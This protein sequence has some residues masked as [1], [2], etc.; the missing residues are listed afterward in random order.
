MAWKSACD[1][2]ASFALVIAPFALPMFLAP[3][4]AASVFSITK[5][6][7]KL[8]TIT[9]DSPAIALALLVLTATLSLACKEPV[10]GNS[11]IIANDVMVKGFHRS[12]FMSK[13]NVESMADC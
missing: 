5:A 13:A 3:A 12:F 9:L 6:M 4:K 10:A 2:P 11:R 8:A 1:R 7:E